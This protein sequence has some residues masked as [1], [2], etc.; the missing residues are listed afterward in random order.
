M[1]WGYALLPYLGARPYTGPGPE[2]DAMFNGIYRCP[3]DSR[4]NVWGYGKSV[5]FELE[6]AETG[7][8]DGRTAGPT[9]HRTVQVPRPAAT[10]IYGEL[11]SGSM[12]DHLM[13]H[14]WY[15]G[16]L[17]EVDTNRHGHTSGYTFVDGHGESRVFSTTFILNKL[18][19][20]HPGRA[21]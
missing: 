21:R 8:I 9:Y 20:W 11:K 12:A 14:F 2:W 17:P 16:G 5:W 1:P 3:E 7:E 18:D 6:S 15:L 4:R 13:A 10:L 19:Q